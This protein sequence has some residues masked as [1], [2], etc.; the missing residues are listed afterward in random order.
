V[1]RIQ[2]KRNSIGLIYA[3]H[4]GVGNGCSRRRKIARF[5]WIRGVIAR[6]IIHAQIRPS[7]IAN[8]VAI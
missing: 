6:R 7:I 8:T 1:K 5:R 4:D 2:I 3:A